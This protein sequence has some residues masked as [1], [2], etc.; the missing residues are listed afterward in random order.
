MEKYYTM[1]PKLSKGLIDEIVK[2]C[3]RRYMEEEVLDSAI[4]AICIWETVK[5]G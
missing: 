4:R 5:Q 1:Y 3:G 2:F